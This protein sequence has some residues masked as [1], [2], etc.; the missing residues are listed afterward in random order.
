MNDLETERYS[1]MTGV[2]KVSV[3]GPFLFLIYITDLPNV[4]VKVERTMIADDATLI[5]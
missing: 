2:P 3:L 5:Q 4:S 1:I